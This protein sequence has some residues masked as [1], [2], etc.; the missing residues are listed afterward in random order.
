M[1]PR[2]G[3]TKRSDE[4]DAQYGSRAPGETIHSAVWHARLVSA[5]YRLT[6]MRSGFKIIR[7]KGTIKTLNFR[8]KLPVYLINPLLGPGYKKARCLNGITARLSAT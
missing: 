5:A 2:W 4:N 3:K 8:V 7:E 6:C 1:L